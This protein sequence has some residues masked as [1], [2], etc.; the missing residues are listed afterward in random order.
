MVTLSQI[1][2]QLNFAGQ[3]GTL[4]IFRQAARVTSV[5]LSLLL[6]IASRESAIGSD[7]YYLSHGYVG[8]DGESVGIMQLNRHYF[9]AYTTADPGN[10][11]R[12][13][14]AGAGYLK[15]LLSEFSGN[16]R[17]AADAYNAG[18]GNVKTALAAG[19]DPDVITT[20]GNYGRD[21]IARQQLI[22]QLIGSTSLM[23]VQTAGG[24]L[25]MLLI[26]SVAL[27]TVFIMIPKI[28]QS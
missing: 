4:P 21:V 25:A 9:P 8:R 15:G 17:Y 22:K 28:K 19:R 14:S 24:G 13:I 27:G 6:A 3:H 2:G 23:P 11:A 26:G 12:I 7:S 5:P 1:Q 18:S 10:N 16:I 20:G